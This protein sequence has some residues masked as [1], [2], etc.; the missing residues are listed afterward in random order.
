M[1]VLK[2]EQQKLVFVQGVVLSAGLMKVGI[3]AEE[4]PI[5][6]VHVTFAIHGYP[7]DKR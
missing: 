1:D 3:E 2:G 6:L 7:N 5:S 4:N